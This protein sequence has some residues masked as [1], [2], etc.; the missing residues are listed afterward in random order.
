MQQIADYEVLQQLGEGS[1]G[2]YWAARPPARLGVSDQTVAVKSIVHAA[3]DAEFARLARHLQLYAS[4][5][6]PCLHRVYDVGQ[7]GNLV[8]IAGEYI[9]EGSLTRPARPFSRVDV[10]RALADAALGAHALHEVGIAHRAIR[11]GNVMLAQ[12]RAK[13]ADVGVSHLLS[14]GQTITGA[15]QMGAIEYLSP[16]IIQGQPAS[17]ASDIWAL[18]ATLHKVLTGVS[19]YPTLPGSSLV[20]ALRFLLNEKPAMGDALRNGER[21]V[22]ES[23]VATDPADRPATAEELAASIS[24]EAARQ[25]E[26][27]QA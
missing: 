6:S 18:G 10:L 13:L 19:I 11:P 16:E 17:R 9:P 7:Q 26:R 22:I 25:A 27:L 12:G 23:V 4:V 24:E 14:P 8:Y 20:E 1:Q 21:R 3:T 2:Q 15:A 5:E